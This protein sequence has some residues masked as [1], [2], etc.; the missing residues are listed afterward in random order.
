MDSLQTPTAATGATLTGGA[1]GARA[2]L[3]AIA[4]AI[5]QLGEVQGKVGAGQNNLMQAIELATSQITN[6]QAAESRVRDADMA[7]EAS[8]MARLNTLQQAGIAALAQ[9][10]Q[11]GQSILSLLR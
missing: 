6:F 1:S 10:N 3:D 4:A 2:A 11:A 5:S 9:A 7:E 8:E